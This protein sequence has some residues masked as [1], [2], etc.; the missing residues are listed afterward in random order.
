MFR[1]LAHHLPALLGNSIAT[2]T[3]LREQTCL[4]VRF[5]GLGISYPVANARFGQDLSVK[6]MVNVS[7]TLYIRAPLNAMVYAR[8]SEKIL[9]AVNIDK[10]LRLECTLAPL[11][12]AANPVAACHMT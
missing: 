4:P 3:T 7:G 10:E 2:A 5:S 12:A 11:L 9:Q 1:Q 8:E 6:V